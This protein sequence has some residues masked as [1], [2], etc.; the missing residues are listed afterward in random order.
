M[1]TNEVYT[2]FVAWTNGGKR[3]P[4]PLVSGVIII[5]SRIWK[6]PDCVRSRILIR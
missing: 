4:S 5:G 6:K 2:A 3:R 1:K